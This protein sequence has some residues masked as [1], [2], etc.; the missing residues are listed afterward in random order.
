MTSRRGLTLV[1]LMITLVML[2]IVGAS[3]GRILMRTFR[4]SDAQL[5][6][7]DMQSNVR[8]GGLILPLEL[9]EIGYD[10]NITTGVVTSDL[11]A[12]AANEIQFR[13]AR[14]FS[15]TCGTPT[16]N[17]FRFRKPVTGVRLP[18]ITDGFL[19]YVENDEN[20]GIDDQWIP[21]TVTAINLNGLCGADSAVV[22]TV[23]TPQVAPGVNLAM[24]NIFVGGPIRYYERMRFGAFVDADGLT[25]LGARSVSAGEA[26]YQAVAGPVSPA[27]G[28][29]F[30]YFARNGNSLDPG[31]A[32]PADA[33]SV[34]VT[35]RGLTR[36][37]INLSGAA[38]RA[39]AGMTTTTLVALRNTL[40][41]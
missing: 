1:E 11:E 38:N 33:R 3:L 20:I 39:R 12:M 21:L 15:T 31:S 9:R 14:G 34:Q 29:Q 2:A 23:T 36:N 13:A 32:D 16:L 28:I 40:K 37:A 5:S 18:R 41:H 17:E 6:Q 35:V 4:V 22:L 30:R 25:Y 24:S 27:N 8:T 7:A 10:S 19:L 26:T